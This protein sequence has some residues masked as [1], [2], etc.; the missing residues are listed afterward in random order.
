MPTLY[1]G[2]LMTI[3]HPSATVAD[4]W[5]AFEVPAM[6]K[7]PAINGEGFHVTSFD[8]HVTYSSSPP[9]PGRHPNTRCSGTH[10]MGSASNPSIV[11]AA[12]ADRDSF[13]EDESD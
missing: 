7:T 9:P 13:C 1:S 8:G 12:E 2:H 6:N 5:S 4:E 10:A 3:S 11:S